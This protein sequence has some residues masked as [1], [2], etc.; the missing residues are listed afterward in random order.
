MTA[1]NQLMVINAWDS[2]VL[3]RAAEAA[4]TTEFVSRV[5]R[6]WGML[7]LRDYPLALK[8]FLR[9]IEMAT[10]PLAGPNVSAKD[11][12]GGEKTRAWWGVRLVS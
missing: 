10:D 3:L 11:T 6:M 5:G 12:P 7:I 2:S 4:Y 8:F 1:L 9:A